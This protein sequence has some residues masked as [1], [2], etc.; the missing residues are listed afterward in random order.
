MMKK[1]LGL[2]F[3]L[4]LVVFVA[5]EASTNE[6]TTDSDTY[7]TEVAVVEEDVN[8]VVPEMDIDVEE[9]EVS[10]VSVVATSP[11]IANILYALNGNV[12]GIPTTTARLPEAF[13]GLP[14]V[15][16]VMETDF[17]L[18]LSLEADLV[19]IDAAF[20]AR[21]ED[22]IN[23][24]GLNVFFFSSRNYDTFLESI[25]G[26]GEK[27]DENE[28]ANTMISDIEDA[29]TDAQQLK[30]EDEGPTVA[31][32]FGAHEDFTLAAET[33][34]FGNLAYLM[35]ARNI[36]NDMDIELDGNFIPVSM[37]Q[38]LLADPDFILRFG[39][40]PMDNVTA[41]F[42]EVLDNNE[43]FQQL[44]AFNEGRVVNLDNTI[45]T[46]SINLRVSEA[47][48]FLGELFYG[49]QE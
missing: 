39:H 16:G 8:A 15:G 33:S 42:D 32:I 6:E 10:R 14:E 48:Q 28:A 5:C 22:Q 21:W 40:G 26:L 1:L 31:I 9:I 47:L 24:L 34:A 19:V 18:I 43:I 44:T 38:I 37:E 36:L 35:G 23:E 2:L 4:S 46:E 11:A 20:E 45:F 12:V 49:D 13:D 27:I 25:Q 30:T 29:L 17:E 41:A 3:M 7:V